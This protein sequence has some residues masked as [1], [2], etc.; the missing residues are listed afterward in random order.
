MYVTSILAVCDVTGGLFRGGAGLEAGKLVC[1]SL[2]GGRRK[3]G[4]PGAA[5][6]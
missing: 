4:N 6:L 5:R 3:A 1:D 2:V